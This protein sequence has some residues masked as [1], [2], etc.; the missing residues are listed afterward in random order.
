MASGRI[1]SASPV[2]G[3][4]GAMV[5][6]VEPT[7]ADTLVFARV[8]NQKICGAF[9]DRYNFRSGGCITLAPRPDCVHLFDSPSG[10]NL[11]P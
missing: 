5:D 1:T 9:A 10:V 4:F 2:G 7:G 6:V 8:G 11:M 3:G